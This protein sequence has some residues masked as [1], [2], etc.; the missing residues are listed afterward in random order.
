MGK[1]QVVRVDRY[2]QVGQED[3]CILE[4]LG[5]PYIQVDQGYLGIQ[6][7]PSYLEDLA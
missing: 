3:H 1:L 6:G 5:V 7:D 4:D 2:I